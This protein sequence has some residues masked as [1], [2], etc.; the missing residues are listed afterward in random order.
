[1]VSLMSRDLLDAAAQQSA[2]RA[3][4][5]ASTVLVFLADQ[6]NV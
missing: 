4:T 6:L 3:D 5:D 2:L 1:M